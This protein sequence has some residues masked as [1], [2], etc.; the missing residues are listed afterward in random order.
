[1]A[2]VSPEF[3][4]IQQQKH[5]CIHWKVMDRTKKLVINRNDSSNINE[6]AE[7]LQQTLENCQGDYVCVTLYTHKPEHL[8]KGSI[9]GQTFDLMVKLNDPYVNAKPSLSGNPSFADLLALHQKIQQYEI[10]KIKAELQSE[11]K[12]SAIDSLVLSFKDHIP[13]L[14]SLVMT[15]LSKPTVQSKI[16]GPEDGG[17]LANALKKLSSIDAD[18]QNT[19]I[20]MAEYLQSNPAVLPQIKTIIGA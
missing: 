5:N 4:R 8:E 16:S 1:M 10:E 19:L 2:F 12:E 7:E 14:I 6:S 3:V 17:K 11:Q 18:Y 9:K 15:K 13:S 20:K